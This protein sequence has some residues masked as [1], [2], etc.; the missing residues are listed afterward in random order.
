MNKTVIAVIIVV[1]VVLGGFLLLNRYSSPQTPSLDSSQDESLDLP[2]DGSLDLSQPVTDANVVRYTD[3]GYEPSTLTV[4][5]GESVT[6]M[7]ES[8]RSLWTASAMHPTHL[9]YD[10]TSLGEH[11]PDA[12]GTAFDQCTAGDE[13]SFTFMESGEWGYHNHLNTSDFGTIVVE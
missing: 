4:S 11:C 1:A 8:G 5:V 13:Y 12:T 7:N 6:F 3:S 2:Q 9:V 10:G